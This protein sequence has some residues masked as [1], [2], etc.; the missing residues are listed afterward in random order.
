M[1]SEFFILTDIVSNCLEFTVHT[2]I[3]GEDQS[4]KLFQLLEKKIWM[5]ILNQL[6]GLKLNTR[7]DN[8][9]KVGSK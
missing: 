2:F 6:I 7:K 5:N 9:M 8:E 1:I 3:R 4:L